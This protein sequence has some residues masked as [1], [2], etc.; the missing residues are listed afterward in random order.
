MTR[1]QLTNRSSLLVA[2]VVAT[3]LSACKDS[4]S[5]TFDD[6]FEEGDVIYFNGNWKV[7]TLCPEER[8]E[9]GPLAV[10]F[11]QDDLEKIERLGQTGSV[12]GLTFEFREGGMVTTG[13]L[14]ED[15]RFL[16]S[17]DEVIG[18]TRIDGRLIETFHMQRFFP[19]GELELTGVLAGEQVDVV[20]STAIG[21]RNHDPTGSRT[22]N[23]VEYGDADR[24]IELYFEP[25]LDVGELRVGLD[26]SVSVRYLTA[27]K[28]FE[29]TATGGKVDVISHDDS[30]LTADF[31]LTF[32]DGDEIAG[33]LTVDW[34][35]RTEIFRDECPRDE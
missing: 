16:S 10:H 1:I 6:I 2:V 34:D 32:R 29:E 22:A 28:S 21:R 8:Q 25:N 30:G 4:V 24:K 23:V 14:T 17:D 26:T 12:D 20:S 9:L 5:D 19:H 7:W 35:L 13:T 3:M 27:G 33:K 18:E 11:R 31:M 15:V